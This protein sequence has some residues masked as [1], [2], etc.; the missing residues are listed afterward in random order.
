LESR[1]LQIPSEIED[2]LDEEDEFKGYNGKITEPGSQVLLRR[3]CRC[4][5][6]LRTTEKRIA[7]PNPHFEEDPTRLLWALK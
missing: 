3:L 6:L 5:L 4:S 7:E 2:Y 1:F